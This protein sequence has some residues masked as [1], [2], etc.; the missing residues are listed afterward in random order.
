MLNDNFAF[1]FFR[2]TYDTNKNLQ[3]QSHCVVAMD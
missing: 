2:A 3:G 1:F